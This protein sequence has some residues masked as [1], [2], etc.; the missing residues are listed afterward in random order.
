MDPEILAEK[1]GDEL[2]FFGG[3][4]VQSTLPMGTPEE[5][6]KEYDRLRNSLGKGGGWICAPT[7]HVQLDT[8]VKNFFHMLNTIGVGTYDESIVEKRLDE[9]NR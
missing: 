8:P 9:I 7:H 6:D 1:Y 5:I 2:C 3:M 4:A